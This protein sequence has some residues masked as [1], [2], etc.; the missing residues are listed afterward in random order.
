MEDANFDFR[1]GLVSKEHPDKV[2]WHVND[3]VSGLDM[4]VT[5]TAVR[6]D[7]VVIEK[8]SKNSSEIDTRTKWDISEE[9]PAEAQGATMVNSGWTF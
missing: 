8:R 3:W 4:D 1:I 2:R 5:L 6:T 7:R 9:W